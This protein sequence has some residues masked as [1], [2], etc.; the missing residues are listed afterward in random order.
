MCNGCVNMSMSR[1]I[2]FQSQWMHW[3]VNTISTDDG[4]PRA[5][6]FIRK[7]APDANRPSIPET[8][9]KEG[10]QK[11]FITLSFQVVKTSKLDEVEKRERAIIFSFPRS[12]RPRQTTQF[13]SGG[14][15]AFQS[16]PVGAH[17]EAAHGRNELQCQENR[18]FT[19]GI[20]ANLTSFDVPQPET[21]NV[22][23]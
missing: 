7:A 8:C 13:P 6:R 12:F 20:S 17:K 3:I 22:F 21:Q 23:N 11:F 1:L 16:T 2:D 18:P 14:W 15:N 9:V 19:A 10:P 5:N 4:Q